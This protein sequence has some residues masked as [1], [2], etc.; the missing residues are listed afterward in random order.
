MR[1]HP[2]SDLKVGDSAELSRV[3]RPGDVAA[4]VD[5]IG[6]H[7]PLHHDHDYAATTRFAKP[8]VPGMWSAGLLSAVLGTQLPGPGCIYVSQR[9]TFTLPVY[10]GDRITARATVVE[11]LPE[12]NRVRIETVCVN[13]D[14]NEVLVGEAL[15]A[16][17]KAAVAYPD[18]TTGA[19]AMTHWS[20]HPWVWG[21]KT[22][23]A[24]ARVSKSMLSAWQPL[25]SDD[26]DQR[27]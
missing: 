17:P 26:Q 9:I 25:D 7:N 12:R 2:I 18:R 21:A 27:R 6:D 1:G 8:I 10:F 4:F 20:L 22:A 15:L 16:P 19:A 5:S 3:A 24:W 11:R 14:G 23:G 13:H